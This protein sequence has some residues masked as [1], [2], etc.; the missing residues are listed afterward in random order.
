MKQLFNF[1]II[2]FAISY[3]GRTQIAQ[4]QVVTD[5]QILADLGLGFITKESSLVMKKNSRGYFEMG[6]GLSV[7]QSC[8]KIYSDKQLAKIF[9]QMLVT[10]LSCMKKNAVSDSALRDLESFKKLLTNKS[11]L[12]KIECDKPLP[13]VAFAIGSSPGTSRNH[14]YIYLSKIGNTDF[15]L[16]P[17]FFKGVVFHELLHNIRYFH[18]PDDLEVT[19]ACEEC[20]FGEKS[21]ASKAEAC[22]VCGG[23]YSDLKDPA[24]LKALITWDALSYGRILAEEGFSRGELKSEIFLLAM[25]SFLIDVKSSLTFKSA[26]SIVQKLSSGNF[27]ESEILKLSQSDGDNRT[28]FFIYRLMAIKAHEL[29][30]VNNEALWRAKAEAARSKYIKT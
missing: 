21:G 19:S 8:F 12:P 22:K 2:I 13:D 28:R 25:K 20:C 23:G 9:Q 7:D 5:Q 18:H 10:G 26:L 4:A 29:N 15:K 17:N 16:K 6:L 1:L 14:P 30:Q 27:D 24:Y 3:L 11:N